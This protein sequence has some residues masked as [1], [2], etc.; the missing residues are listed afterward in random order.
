MSAER[1]GQKSLIILMIDAFAL[2]SDAGYTPAES[3]I[4]STY[5]SWCIYITSVLL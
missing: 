3:I 2:M 4:Y 1:L 5:I